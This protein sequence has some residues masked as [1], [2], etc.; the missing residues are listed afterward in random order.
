MVKNCSF[1]I[2]NRHF[3]VHLSSKVSEKLRVD[4]KLHHLL[5]KPTWKTDKLKGLVFSNQKT[6]FFARK[7][8]FVVFF[9]VK[10]AFFLKQIDIFSSFDVKS[11]RKAQV[12][13]KLQHLLSKPT[14]KTDK[15]KGLVFFKPKHAFFGQK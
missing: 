7:F 13:P 1:L 8:S 12:D 10:I 9:L 3:S 4:P 15:L 5:G 11:F 2:Q 14:W 6:C